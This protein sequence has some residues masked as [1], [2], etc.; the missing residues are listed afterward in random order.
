MTEETKPNAPDVGVL[1]DSIRKAGKAQRVMEFQCPYISD[2]FVN[3]AFA[4]KFIMTQIIDYAK[5]INTNFR[6]GVQVE[7]E[8]LNEDR[9]REGYADWVVVGWKGLTGERLQK[10][11]PGT[12]IEGAEMT[13]EIPYSREIAIALFEVSLEFE[14]W[15]IGMATELK[16]YT[17]VSEKKKEQL[18]NLT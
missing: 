16:N 18:A 11:I 7:T 15:V 1:A 14:T 12:K 5:E 4:N 10:L 8:K 6:R 3:L 17:R 2:F 9:L 13:K